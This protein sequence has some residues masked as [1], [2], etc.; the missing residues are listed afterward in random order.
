MIKWQICVDK[1]ASLLYDNGCKGVV[2]K[3]FVKRNTSTIKGKTYTSTLLVEGYRNKDG[4][5]RHRTLCNLSKMPPALIAQIEAFL[6]GAPAVRPDDLPSS[7]SREFGSLAAV[8]S[9]LRDIGLD[10]MIYSRNTRWRRLVCLMIAAR[11]IKQGSKLSIIPWLKDAAA[12]N[13]FGF[14][15][16]ALDVQD[17]YC[18]LDRLLERQGDIQKQLAARS[19]AG[20]C[21]VLYDLTST[22]FEGEGCPLARFGYNRDGKRG[23]LQVVIGMTTDTQ[24]RPVSIEVFEGN[25]KDSQTMENKIQELKQTYGLNEIIFVAD[26]GLSTIGNLEKL[27]A[28]GLRH[29]SAMTHK[30][31]LKKTEEKNS[32]LQLGLFDARHIAEVTDPAAPRTRWILCKNEETARRETATRAALMEKTEAKL[33]ALEQTVAKGKRK[34]RDGILTQAVKAVNAYRV[35]KF[36]DYEAGEGSFRWWI[37]Q[38]TLEREQQLDGCYVITSDASPDH[39][40]KEELVENYKRLARI[41]SAWRQMKTVQLEIRPVWHWKP[42]RVRAHIFLCMLAYLVQHEM[43]R[44]LEPLFHKNGTGKNRQWTFD[45]ALNRL[46]SLREEERQI[47]GQPFFT[48]TKPDPEQA[49]ILQLLGV[50]YPEL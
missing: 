41:E 48:H 14:D 21:L 15:R 47:Q 36:Y 24:G 34:K 44:R 30:A 23:K 1:S 2:S 18:A 25:T 11:V 3:M 37:K 7:A 29:I 8:D 32:P 31:M 12:D 13:V 26:R 39:L 35:A 46:S 6:K 10:R 4:K 40:T 20:G 28:A 50:K 27:R 43:L 49:Q 22:Y 33:R 5:P 42:D 19:L 16:D 38:D 17:L 9:V 45:T